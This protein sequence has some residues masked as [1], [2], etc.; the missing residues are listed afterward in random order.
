MKCPSEVELNEYAEDRLDTRRRWEVQEHLEECAE[1]RSDLE[2]LQWTT[3]RLALLADEVAETGHPS[4]EELA[5]MAE[6]TLEGSQ[7]ARVLTHLGQCPE[8]AAIYGALPRRKRSFVVPRSLSGLAAAAALLL[9]IGIFY[10]TGGYRQEPGFAP[11]P[12]PAKEMAAP[13]AK[14]DKEP[15]AEKAAPAKAIAPAAEKVTTVKTAAM[16][17]GSATPATGLKP[18]APGSAVAPPTPP[19]APVR[20]VVETAP[21]VVPRSRVTNR[22]RHVGP[23]PARVIKVV[24]SDGGFP[25]ATPET[26][27]PATA[28]NRPA[29]DWAKAEPSGGALKSG[30]S[31]SGAPRAS[32]RPF[33]PAAVVRGGLSAP[34]TRQAPLPAAPAPDTIDRAAAEGVNEL[35]VAPEAVDRLKNK[36]AT[37]AKLRKLA[38]QNAEGCSAPGAKVRSNRLDRDIAGKVKGNI[39]TKARLRG[40]DTSHQH[41]TAKDKLASAPAHSGHAVQGGTDGAVGGGAGKTVAQDAPGHDS[42]SAQCL[43]CLSGGASHAGR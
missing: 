18:A 2:T 37:K 9:A 29:I 20:P 8:C 1:C 17:G 39:K 21:S 4:D 42:A 22:H 13:V 11:P 10:V 25:E 3:G 28:P 32:E 43:D 5:A 41:G 35:V 6:G 24:P 26:L 23:P 14:E 40:T 15:V 19:S 33:R 34:T 7:R 27:A 30:T 36:A 16:P 12:R 31:I 38:R